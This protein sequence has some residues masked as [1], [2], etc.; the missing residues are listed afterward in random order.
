MSPRP[1]VAMK[2]IA[3]GVANWAAIVRSPSF[4]RSAAST[5]TTNLPSRMSSRA[6]SMVVNG[7]VSTF[8]DKS[9]L[10]PERPPHSPA[11]ST[12]LARLRCDRPPRAIRGHRFPDE[13][14]D[15]QPDVV[16]PR[17]AGEHANRVVEP[18]VAFRAGAVDD[19]SRDL[20]SVLALPREPAQVEREQRAV[21]GLDDAVEIGHVRVFAPQSRVVQPAEPP[22]HAA[23]DAPLG[24]E[25]AELVRPAR[26]V[27]LR[28][29]EAD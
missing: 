21:V 22:A 19:R 11:V 13:L 5:T 12:P 16:S 24:E 1:C 9:Y 8:T 27:V 6:A 3:S 18:P 20:A 26:E 10:S 14:G 17:L 15:L 28:V 23:V 25:E 2:L 29:G 4:S 7:V